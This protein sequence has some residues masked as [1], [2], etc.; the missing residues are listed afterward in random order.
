MLE[1]R[2]KEE[3]TLDMEVSIYDTARN[4]KAK[5]HRAELVRRRTCIHMFAF[6]QFVYISIW[7]CDAL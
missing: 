3:S 7:T 4:E 2:M 1:L 5:K 6:M